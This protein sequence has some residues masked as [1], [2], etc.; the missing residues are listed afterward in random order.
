MISRLKYWLSIA[1]FALIM[2]ACSSNGSYVVLV[3]ATPSDPAASGGGSVNIEAI[4]NPTLAAVPGVFPTPTFI[5][6]P[7]PTRPAIVD[8]TQEQTYIVQ[9]G[10]TLGVIATAFGV[11]VESLVAANNLPNENVL[12]VGQT[13]VIPG[14][15][16][17]YG[18]NFKIIPDC[19][20]VWGPTVEDFSVAEFLEGR[21]SFLGIYTEEMNGF[22]WTG[23]ELVERAAMEQGINPKLLLAL[24]EYENGWISKPMITEEAAMFPLNYSERP[25]EIYGLYRQLDWAGKMLQTGYYGWRLRGLASTLLVDGTRAGLDPTLNAGTAGVQVLLAQTRNYDQWWAA[26]QHS[27]FFATYNQLFGDPFINAVEPLLPPDLTQPALSFPWV[28]GETWY[29]TGGPHGGWGSSSAWAALDFVVSVEDR[30]CEIPPGWARAVAD[31][32]IAYTGYGLVILD[33]DNDGDPGTGWTI[34]Y[35]HMSSLDRPVVEGQKISQGDPIAKTSCEGGVSF[36]S[37]L[38]IARRYNGEWIAA[39]CSYCNLAPGIPSVPLIFEG[40][41]AYSFGPNNEY[42]GSLVN[43]D[44]YREAYAGGRIDLNTFP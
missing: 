29:Y 23:A 39:D 34:Y 33:L 20:L 26:T 14:A 30:G 31:G 19:E 15:V 12:E 36:S 18:P 9:R 5:P 10:D 28:A 2:A 41:T 44:A 40:W 1:F 17:A 32:V 42:D 38:H 13:L 22:M 6:T 7:N 11:S 35:L 21:D 27:G 16:T 25:G 43:G 4:P 3:T 8:L 37:H 24:L